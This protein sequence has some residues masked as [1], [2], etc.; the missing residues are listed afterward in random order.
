MHTSKQRNALK[1]MVANSGKSKAQIMR[2]VGY[3]ERTARSPKKLTESKGWLE[4]QKEYLPDKDTLEVHKESLHATKIISANITYGEANEKTND[5]IEVP[6][7]KVRLDAVKLDYQVKGRLN[8]GGN[9]NIN[10][11][12]ILVLPAELIAKHGITHD[13]E[14]RSE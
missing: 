11:A 14:D 10:E 9:I 4:L 12:K 3:S 2:D 8:S 1:E 7:H 6:D 13:T 5:F